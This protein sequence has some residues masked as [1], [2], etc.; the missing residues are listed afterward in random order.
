MP[1]QSLQEEVLAFGKSKCPDRK[2]LVTPLWAL[3][4]CTAHPEQVC[5]KLQWFIHPYN[6]LFGNTSKCVT[7]V[8]CKS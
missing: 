5:G 2:G 7:E 6:H 4:Q 3:T 1:F 8:I